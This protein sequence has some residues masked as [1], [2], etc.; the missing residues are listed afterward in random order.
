MKLFQDYKNA[1]Q[2]FKK[3]VEVE[4]SQTWRRGKIC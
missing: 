3:Q 4:E 1:I 2:E